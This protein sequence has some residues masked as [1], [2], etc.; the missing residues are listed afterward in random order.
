MVAE[1]T[2]VTRLDFDDEYISHCLFPAVSK[3]VEAGT[4][5]F[6]RPGLFKE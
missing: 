4:A 6:L 1:D 3:D 2:E 5:V